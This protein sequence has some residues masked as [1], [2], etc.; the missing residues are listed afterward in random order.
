MGCRRTSC[1]RLRNVASSTLY[2]GVEKVHLE[3][4]VRKDLGNREEADDVALVTF[5]AIL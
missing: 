4:Y 3:E 5:V 2:H 1:V